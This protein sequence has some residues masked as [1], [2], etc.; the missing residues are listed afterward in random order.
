MG[1]HASGAR[2]LS[3]DASWRPGHPFRATARTVRRDATSKAHALL[4]ELGLEDRWND[5][6]DKLSGGMQQR[7]QLATSLVHDPRYRPRRAVRRSGPTSSGEPVR[8]LAGCGPAVAGPSFSPATSSTSS[9]ISARTSRWSTT[10]ARATRRRVHSSRIVRPAAA[11][12]A[13]DGP[14]PRL[15]PCL[16]RRH[17]GH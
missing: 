3:R 14:E 4:A 1:L 13:R 6:T 12:T 17:R 10:A 2:A 11:Q 5:R 8:D 16:P 7:L 15:A 9:R